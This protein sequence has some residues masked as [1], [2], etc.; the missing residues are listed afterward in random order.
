MTRMIFNAACFFV[1]IVPM[2]GCADTV[3]RR[4]RP[5]VSYPMPSIKQ[6]CS[7][8]HVAAGSHKASELKKKLSALCLDCHSNRK[9]PA[10]HLVDIVPSMAVKGLPLT[11]GMITCFTCHD[12]HRNPYGSLLR[13]KETDLCLVCHPV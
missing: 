4:N 3:G 5:S 7:I 13:M 10:E 8:C 9:A 2:I 6:D 1:L 11:D 12:P